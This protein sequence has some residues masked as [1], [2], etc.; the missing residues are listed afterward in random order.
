MDGERRIRLPNEVLFTGRQAVRRN[1]IAKHAAGSRSGGQILRACTSRL[2]I[3][4]NLRPGS[5][6][7]P[8]ERS[9]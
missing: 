9:I 2:H 3:E 7:R 8:G 1:T 5:S 6:E 4:E